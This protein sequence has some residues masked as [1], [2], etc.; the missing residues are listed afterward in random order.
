MAGSVLVAYATKRGSTREVA[1]AVAE[2]L[3]GQ[4][5]EVELVPAAEAKSVEKF[6]AVVIG[7]ALYSGRWRGSRM[8]KRRRR[9]LASKPVAVFAMGPRRAADIVFTR[10]SQQLQRALA[11]VP[12]VEPV[13]SGVFGGVDRKKGIDLRDWDAIRAWAE[14][15]GDELA[16]TDT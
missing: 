4:G 11:R 3:R 14:A 10:A 13:A 15:V 1:E 12:E 8:L 6:D 16:S 9:A 5:F 7:G 2:T